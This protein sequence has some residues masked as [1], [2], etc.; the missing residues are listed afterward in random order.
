MK[1]ETRIIAVNVVVDGCCCNWYIFGNNTA[2]IARI[3][4][5]VDDCCCDNGLLLETNTTTI[6]VIGDVVYR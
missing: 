5:V 3:N 1:T 2:R 6:I 4:V